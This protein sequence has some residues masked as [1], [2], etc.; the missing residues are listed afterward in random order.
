MLMLMPCVEEENQQVCCGVE[1]LKRVSI[2]FLLSTIHN[3]GAGMDKEDIYQN[4]EP[5]R[6]GEDFS[7]IVGQTQSQPMKYS[8]FN[9]AMEA[10][11]LPVFQTCPF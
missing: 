9:Q 8:F 6:G 4:K 5:M 3:I 2:S 11:S 10:E 1:E 7:P